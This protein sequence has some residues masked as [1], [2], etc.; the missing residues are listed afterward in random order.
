LVTGCAAQGI[1]RGVLSGT[2]RG[3]KDAGGS[4]AFD[5]RGVVQR[6]VPAI[7]RAFP[8]LAVMTDVC[9]CA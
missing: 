9:L 3:A 1:V 2:D 7:K 5:A 4:G 6:A 8:E